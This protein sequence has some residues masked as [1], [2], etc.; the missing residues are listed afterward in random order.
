MSNLLQQLGSNEAVLMM[1]VADELPPEDRAEVERRLAADAELHAD[2]ERLREADASFSA[3]MGALDRSTRLPVPEAVGAKQVARAMRQWHADRVARPPAAE[4]RIRLRYPRWAYPVAA[5]AAVVIGFVAWWGNSD[6]PDT[7]FTGRNLPLR[8]DADERPS[9]PD[10][11][12]AMIFATSSPIDPPDEF[13]S[14]VDPSDYAILAPLMD[15]SELGGTPQT[16]QEPGDFE[17]EQDD[18]YLYL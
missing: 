9:A 1:Y 11:L 13:A 3:A 10:M 8:F 2:L 17:R 18:W 16:E 14:L 12:A 15:A 5:A 6:R 7:R 4:P